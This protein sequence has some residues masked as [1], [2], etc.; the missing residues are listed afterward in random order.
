[1]QPPD[2]VVQALAGRVNAKAVDVTHRNHD[3]HPSSSESIESARA[4]LRTLPRSIEGDNGDS[5]LFA[6]A[7]RLVLD[8]DLTPDQ[9]MPL[10]RE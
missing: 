3:L 8:F 10:L 5:Q 2:L 4:Y 1:M 7:C 9:A 6:V